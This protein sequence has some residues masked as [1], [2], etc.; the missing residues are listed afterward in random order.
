[1]ND[2]RPYS[3]EWVCCSV[4]PDNSTTVRFTVYENGAVNIVNSTDIVDDEVKLCFIRE[5]QKGAMAV[6]FGKRS[7][8][9]LLIEWKAHNILYKKGLFKK[10]TIE[11]C[12][13]RNER[14]Y[15]RAF[16]R[17]VCFIFNEK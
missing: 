8:W 1:M 13:D 14:W 2:N 16:Y 17:F 9:S 12:L 6:D 7:E 10:H 15:R 5:V 4:D 11:A 3:Y